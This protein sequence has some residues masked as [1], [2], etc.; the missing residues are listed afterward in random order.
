MSFSDAVLERP[1][2]V[3]ATDARAS[4]HGAAASL[5]ESLRQAT[6]ADDPQGID[7]AILQ[8]LFGALCEFYA[9]D[10]VQ[11][12]AI[13]PLHTLDAA[14]PTAVLMTTTALLRGANLE[15]FELGMWQTWSGMK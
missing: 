2:P 8:E 11:R 6:A 10:V 5:A 1:D 3:A 14:S 13:T 12:G 15:L 9:S 4:L 7:F